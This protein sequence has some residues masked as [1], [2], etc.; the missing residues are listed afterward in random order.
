MLRFRLS[1]IAVLVATFGLLSANAAYAQCPYAIPAVT[2]DIEPNSLDEAGNVA[3]TAT[4]DI[5]C[6]S[7]DVFNDFDGQ[8]ASGGAGDSFN[9]VFAFPE[10]DDDTEITITAVCNLPDDCSGQ[11]SDILTLE[12]DDDGRDDDDDGDG[13]DGDDKDNNGA[14]P[15]TGG[16]DQSAILAG[17]ALILAGGGAIFLARRKN[18]DT[19]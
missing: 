7:W 11:A 14:L 6:D 19:A 8:T 3:G 4:S 9:F 1:A 12:G 16:S 17:I 15:D 10:V 5:V 18:E 13:D 2:V